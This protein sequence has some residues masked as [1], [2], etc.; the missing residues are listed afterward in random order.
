MNGLSEL[1]FMVLVADSDESL[2]SSLLRT[3]EAQGL[4]GRIAISQSAVL[5]AFR[6]EDLALVILSDSLPD[7]DSLALC[8][9]LTSGVGGTIPFVILLS[10]NLSEKNRIA[11]FEAG[12][13]DFVGKPL[14][15][16][17]VAL[18][19]NAIVR[20]LRTPP[21]EPKIAI[22][23]IEIFPEQHL[24]RVN[25]RPLSLTKQE[26]KLLRV[27]AEQGGRVLSRAEILDCVW[28]ED[29]DILD[30]TV[31]AHVQGL[32]A[33]L[34]EAASII[35]TVHGVG[36][37]L[38]SLPHSSENG[39]PTTSPKWRIPAT[40]TFCLPALFLTPSSRTW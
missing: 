28:G 6:A 30:R 15:T 10:S 22:S 33:K 21:C 24:A 1:P 7:C 3:L 18:R 12:A 26:L 9:R 2:A 36:Y 34:G 8:R 32:R 14:S 27:M 31:D 20:R 4:S 29:K 35:E 25:G 19:A 40:T 16:R 11:A 13:I 37:R 5:E 17:E 23:G 39:L 38:A